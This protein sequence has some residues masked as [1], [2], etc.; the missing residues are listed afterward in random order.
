MNTPKTEET[1]KP[2][3]ADFIFPQYSLVLQE[4]P[5]DIKLEEI[6]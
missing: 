6:E 4:L 1:K 3:S 5:K 2:Q